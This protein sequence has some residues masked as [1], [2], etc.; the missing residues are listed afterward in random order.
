MV[1]A[2]SAAP[3]WGYAPGAAGLSSILVCR[4]SNRRVLNSTCESTRNYSVRSYLKKR[5]CPASRT[6]T[7]GRRPRGRNSAFHM[8]HYGFNGHVHPRVPLYASDETLKLLK[9]T[10][11]FFDQ[12]PA[13]KTPAVFEWREPFLNVARLRSRRISWTRVPAAPM[14]S[15]LRPGESRSSTRVTFATTENHLNASQ[16][17]SQGN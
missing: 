14:P 17:R 15:W 16:G 5:F 11:Q 9:L 2:R 4:W 10:K 12:P 3:V 8:D 6:F 13:V 1:A 7:N